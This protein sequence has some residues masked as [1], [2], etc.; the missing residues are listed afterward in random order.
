MNSSLWSQM[1]LLIHFGG[2]LGLN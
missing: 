1:G 2:F